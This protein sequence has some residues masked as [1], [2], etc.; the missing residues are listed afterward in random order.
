MKKLFKSENVIFW[1][2]MTLGIIFCC[3]TAWHVPWVFVS[4]I[5]IMALCCFALMKI[6]T[7]KWRV[8][9]GWTL[10]VFLV[11]STLMLALVSPTETRV[12]F[13][14][15]LL[16][17][18]GITGLLLIVIPSAVLLCKYAADN[19][20]RELLLDSRSKI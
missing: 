10:V 15:A 1:V 3:T 16:Y 7:H 13:S 4:S 8:A 17:L 6:P 14:K 5:I 12:L 11:S 20:T 18:L 2:L 9:F 19:G